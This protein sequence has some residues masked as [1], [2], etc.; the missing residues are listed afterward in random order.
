M[1]QPNQKEFG[2]GLKRNLLTLLL[3]T[4]TAIFT[5]GCGDD[6]DFVA[7]GGGGFT[8][9]ATTGDLVFNFT[10]APA[11]AIQVPSSTTDLDFE[12]F[13]AANNSV[14]TYTQAYADTV[15]VSGVPVSATRVVI[16]ARGPGGP[17]AIIEAPVTVV[18]GGSVVV[19]L[20]GAT[21]TFLGQLIVEPETLTFAPGGLIGAIDDLIQGLSS[22]D[23]I[24]NVAFFRAYFVPAGQTE[25]VEVTARVGVHFTNFAPS[26]VTADSFTYLNVVGE[27][28]A[29]TTNPLAPTPPF[30]ATCDMV[31]TYIDTNGNVFTDSVAVTLDNPTLV[32]V[33]VQS[34][35]GGTLVL[36]ANGVGAFPIFAVAQYSNGAEFPI[37]DLEGD[38]NNFPFPST[39]VMSVQTP[40]TGLNI[41]DNVNDSVDNG[42][43]QTTGGGAGSTAVL[44][45]TANGAA[46][47][48]TTFNV[49]LSSA[50]A[51]NE[52]ALSVNPTAINP[53]GGYRVVATY[54]NGDTQD[55]TGV[56][57]E[58]DT[59]LNGPTDSGDVEFQGIF[60]SVGRV[61]GTF[62]GTCDIRID[63]NT[64]DTTQVNAELTDLSL[65]GTDTSTT[66]NSVS[67]NVLSTVPLSIIGGIL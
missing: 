50:T 3:V 51:V 22:G 37:V 35:P 44:A 20:S 57:D 15:V 5:V 4:L 61:L 21:I 7:T 13:D 56:W 58:I 40:A 1:T 27:G 49:R 64:G 46:T 67:V 32:G 24:D 31:V 12:F 28:I 10:L 55:L 59:F 18:A 45:I 63:D 41:V 33:D 66:N 17:V 42:A 11:Q 60:P 8:P 14:L 43:L 16:T 65:P 29:I 53:Q 26:S 36:P 52:V 38:P 23:Q 30:G 19:D 25:R 2:G 47:P 62:R 6:N 54:D 9:V 34:A 48:I 39:F